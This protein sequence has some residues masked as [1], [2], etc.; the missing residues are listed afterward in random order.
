MTLQHA[1]RVVQRIDR[2]K[3]LKRLRVFLACGFTPLHLKTFIHACLIER[4]PDRDTEIKTG[5]YG[6]LRG[7]IDL[8]KAEEPDICFVPIEWGDLDGRLDLR[9]L[10][11]WDPLCLQDILNDARRTLSDLAALLGELAT[12]TRVVVSLPT[13]PLP[14]ISYFPASQLSGFDA[15]LRMLE[16]EF[17]ERVIQRDVSIIDDG[18]LDRSLS[19]ADRR[20]VG[21]DLSYGFPYSREHAADLASVLV[22][23]ISTP[24][25]MKGIITDLD[26]TCWA[27]IVGEIGPDSVSWDLAGSAQI[28]GLYQQLLDS[29]A[30]AGIFVAVASKNDPSVVEEVFRRTDIVMKSERVFPRVIGWHP[31]SESVRQILK[32]WNIGAESVL[33]VDD[34]AMELAEIKRV[35]PQ[36]SVIQFPANDPQAAYNVLQTIRD[37]FGRTSLR[38]EDSLRLD[39]VRNRVEFE[40]EAETHAGTMDDFLRDLDG[41]IT[42]DR[43]KHPSN[44]R[45]YELINKTN[46]FNMN[47]VRLEFADWSRHLAEPAAFQWVI[48]Y[49]DKYGPLGAI[50][51]VLGSVQQGQVKIDTW[52]MSCRA[53]SRRIEHMVLKLLFDDHS[54]SSLSLDYRETPRNGPFR[55][56]LSCY[57]SALQ[58]GPIVI[59]SAALVAKVPP[60]FLKVAKGMGTDTGN[61]SA[62]ER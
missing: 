50:S 38:K 44:R 55:D 27:G 22:D 28:H 51:V 31:K 47:G 5:L 12:H 9:R 24:P 16:Y 61:R 54:A 32:H 19:L 45:P 10:G 52:V 42:V 2:R 43:I 3:D 11:S 8:A 4:Y 46:Q 25:L 34:S 7:S 35:F 37:L 58:P 36:I 40:R 33:C 60:V 59:T 14:P 29:L 48:D 39:T 30:G 26:D 6:D 23:S 53:F 21:S 41:A 49:R 62:A 56:F 20:D 15:G 18:K 17:A 57:T 13:L 1:L